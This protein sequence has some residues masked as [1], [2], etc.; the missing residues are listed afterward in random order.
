[1]A[2]TQTVTAVN[3]HEAVH[4]RLESWLASK[5]DDRPSC[6]RLDH[7]L[8]QYMYDRRIASALTKHRQ[9]VVGSQLNESTDYCDIQRLER[10]WCPYQCICPSI[11]ASYIG[12][13]FCHSQPMF[14]LVSSWQRD[15]AIGSLDKNRTWL[16][17]DSNAKC[18]PDYLLHCP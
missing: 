17:C 8:L 9:A 1:M 14:S 16:D 7:S 18:C 12:C 3:I 13:F 15:S 11:Q 5:L 10:L 6:T 2:Y 4:S